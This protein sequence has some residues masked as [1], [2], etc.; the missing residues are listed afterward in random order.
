MPGRSP[1]LGKRKLG[2]GSL[3]P[4][5]RG[6]LRVSRHEARTCVKWPKRARTSIQPKYNFYTK[7]NL[8]TIVFNYNSHKT[9][10]LAQNFTKIQ[11]KASLAVSSPLRP[12][13]RPIPKCVFGT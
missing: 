1:E 5:T 10:S 13:M 4:S 3:N 6:I 9:G 2:L 12:R 7:W 11:D 8:F